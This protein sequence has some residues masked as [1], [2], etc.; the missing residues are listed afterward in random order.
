MKD[1]T[2]AELIEK[3]E[4]QKHLASAVEAKDIEMSKLKENHRQLVDSF[5][6]EIKNMKEEIKGLKHNAKGLVHLSE[7]Q[8]KIDKVKGE[9]QKLVETTNLYIR[10]Y[11]NY[12]KQTQHNLEMALFTEQVISD[13]F[14]K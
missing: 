1:L 10:M 5:K 6:E 8:E 11:H 9:N 14:K 12:L 7:V 3:L 2:K 4:E 13:K